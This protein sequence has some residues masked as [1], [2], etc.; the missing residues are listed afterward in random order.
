MHGR[1]RTASLVLTLALAA[2]L[3]LLP[4]CG[5]APEEA[6]PVD[7]E[8]TTVEEEWPLDELELPQSNPEIG[9]TLKTAPSGLVVTYNGE[10]WLELT[11]RTHPTLHYT[12]VAAIPDSPAISPVSPE[13]FAEMVGR[14]PGGVLG[15]SGE[16]ET[17][18]GS[19][20]WASATYPQDGAPFEDVRLYAVHP[21]TGG[22]LILFSV[23]PEGSVSLEDR[24]AIFRELLANIE[25]TA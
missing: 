24:L 9:I 21:T 8:I 7:E 1:Y 6:P 11:D 5:R 17:A 22:T 18:V 23:G 14:H 20:R 3:G 15:P 25:P 13:T 19:A 4:G 12:F 2:S 16:L 10:H